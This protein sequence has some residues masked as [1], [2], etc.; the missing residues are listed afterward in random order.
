MG[1]AD[2][3]PFSGALYYKSPVACTDSDSIRPRFLPSIDTGGNRILHVTI[4]NFGL[5]RKIRG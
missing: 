3:N 5:F 4:Y 2:D 1:R